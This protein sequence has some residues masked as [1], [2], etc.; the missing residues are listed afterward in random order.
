MNAEEALEAAVDALTDVIDPAVEASVAADVIDGF[1]A[2]AKAYGL[3]VLELA[4]ND[5]AGLSDDGY[6]AL[7]ARIERGD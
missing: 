1:R 3:W 6:D 4:W 5:S 7:R 2:Y